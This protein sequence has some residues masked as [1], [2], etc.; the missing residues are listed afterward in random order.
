[1]TIERDIALNELVDGYQT[2][3]NEFTTDMPDYTIA[4]HIV[5]ELQ[6]NSY[7]DLTDLAHLFMQRYTGEQWSQLVYDFFH[8]EG[9]HRTKLDDLLELYWDH[10]DEQE[11][12]YQDEEQEQGQEVVPVG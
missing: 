12:P 9:I 1:M 8:S 6:T 5:Y 4:M 11:Q 2:F 3:L 10:M 7:E